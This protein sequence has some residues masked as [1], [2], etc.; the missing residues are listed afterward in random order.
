LLDTDGSP[1]GCLPAIDLALPW[2]PQT[3]DLLGA[4]R[5]RFG[6]EAF[7]V[8]LLTASTSRMEPGAEVTYAVELLGE[9][10]GR[11][12]L[13]PCDVPLGD[14]AD[15]FRMPWARV[16]GVAADITWADRQLAALGWRRTGAP[17]QVRS[18]NLSLLLRLPTDHGVVWLKHAPPF[19][20]HEGALLRL[21]HDAGA[22]V[23][24][25]I[26]GDH[27]RGLAVLEDIPGED[28][29]DPDYE[30]AARMVRSLVTLQH[31]MTSSLDAIRSTGSPD[32]TRAAFLRDVL[33]MAA[34]LDVRVDL[35]PG[36]QAALDRLI[37][38]LPTRLDALY[39]CGLMDTLV[40]GDFHPRN[41]RFDR[42][43][44][45]L[46]DW[47]DSGVG[48]PLLDMTAF[49][50]RF[51]PDR[52]YRVRVAW[53]ATW[54]QACPAADVARAADLIQPIAALR[55]ALIYRN[56]LDR[57]ESSEQVYHREDPAFWLRRAIALANPPGGR[58]T[59]RVSPS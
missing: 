30:L 3:S 9:L 14:D 35:E 6:F 22:H 32:W 23:P 45:V 56:F 44:L 24:A 19:M 28:V 1:L 20:R 40:H 54:K 51:P 5:E 33:G 15:P 48:H 17:E 41:H 52:R 21:V 55:Q 42:D 34:R 31:G 50:E 46:I 37:A 18:W 39:A 8:R 27:E 11:L 13:S 4:L 38:D 47:G 58:V 12:P 10:P 57:I 7:V 49:L 36:E 59:G 2:W 43:R 25:V 26:A 16:G 53:I 29:S